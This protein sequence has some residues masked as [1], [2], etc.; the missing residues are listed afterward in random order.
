[1]S[2]WSPDG[3]NLPAGLGGFSAARINSPT[4]GDA[5]RFGNYNDPNP[6]GTAGKGTPADA[7]APFVIDENFGA[8]TPGANVLKTTQGFFSYAR[9]FGPTTDDSAEGGSSVAVLV[10]TGAPFTQAQP[11]VGFEGIAIAQGGNILS[12]KLIGVI[13]TATVQGTAQVTNAIGLYVS[14][15]SG[16]A[17]AGA[18]ITN[19]YG[20]FQETP[21]VVGTITNK[22]GGYFK[23]DLQI[24]RHLL[25]GLIGLQTIAAQAFVNGPNVSG[26]AADQPSLIVQ[27]GAGQTA[28]TLKLRT[29]AGAD[30]LQMFGASGNILL[31]AGATG[32]GGVG[33]LSLVTTTAPTGTPPAAG[34]YLYVDPADNKLKAKTSGGT[35]TILTPT[36]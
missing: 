5:I 36:A 33:E 23:D 2:G 22:W 7:F 4:Y 6:F 21:Q 26:G 9:Y 30:R 8:G 24:E 3:G 13:G 35:V 28:A 16:A 27:Q 31:G 20:L 1:V 18:L 14:T 25:V 11:V 17:A 10:D 15:L 32:G 12:N 29:S 19:Y 34:A